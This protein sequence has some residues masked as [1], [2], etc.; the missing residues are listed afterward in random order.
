MQ[1]LNDLV[2]VPDGWTLSQE[3][4]IADNGIIV[5]QAAGDGSELFQ[6]EGP[7]GLDVLRPVAEARQAE[8]PEIDPGKKGFAEPSAWCKD[9]DKPPSRLAALRGLRLACQTLPG[10]VCCSTLPIQSLWEVFPSSPTRRDVPY[11]EAMLCQQCL[12]VRSLHTG[13][14]GCSGNIVVAPPQRLHKKGPFKLGDRLVAHPLSELVQLLGSPWGRGA[15]LSDGHGL[16][17]VRLADAWAA[18]EDCQPL[19]NVGKFANVAR[20]VVLHQGLHGLVGEVLDTFVHSSREYREKVAGQQRDVLPPLAQRRK[21]HGEDV[22]AIEQILSELAV[23][24]DGSQ[25]PVRGGDEAYVHVHRLAGAD[26]SN[27]AFLNHAQQRR[28]EVQRKVADLV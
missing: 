6:L 26:R 4:D 13:L 18:A 8:C 11:P 22:E 20:P 15:D 12:E 1:D 3:I 9:C 19:H 28:L 27:L 23:L 10:T 7:V 24:H 21:P 14:L 2:A 25:V 5:G 17:Q 16:A